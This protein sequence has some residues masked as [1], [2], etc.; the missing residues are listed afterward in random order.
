MNI[1]DL[2]ISKLQIIII[3]FL[4]LALIIGLYLVQK[5]Q[6][7]KPKAVTNILNAFDLS[8]DKGNPLDCDPTTT[9]PICRTSSLDIKIKLKPGGLEELSK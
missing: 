8:D 7:F 2:N 9:Q 6:V 4:A 5:V 1:A 3:V